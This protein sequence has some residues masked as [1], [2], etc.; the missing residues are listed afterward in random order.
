MGSI[1]EISKDNLIHELRKE[2]GR[3]GGLNTLKKHGKEHFKML[4]KAR[5]EKFYER[6]S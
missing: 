6:L 3:L 4:A 5:W 1:M 2:M